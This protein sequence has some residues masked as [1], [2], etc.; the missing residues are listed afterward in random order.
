MRIASLFSSF[1]TWTCLCGVACTAA[2]A[3]PAAAQT[4]TLGR[5][6]PS[7]FEIIAVDPVSEPLWPF[8]N[9]DLA[10]DGQVTTTDTEASIDLRSVYADARSGRLWLRAYVAAKR[11]NAST[12]A[13]TG[14]FIDTDQNVATGGKAE[15]LADA[16]G[17]DASRGGYEV[18]LVVK[19][20][21]TLLG[22][23]TWNPTDRIWADR[24]RPEQVANVERGVARDPLRLLGDDRVYA[25]VSI[26]LAELKLDERCLANI[27][28]RTWNDQPNE[29]AYDDWVSS[30]AMAC[31]ARLNEFGDPEVLRSD[32]CDSDDSCPGNGV[33]RD[34][35][36]L[37]SYECNTQASCQADQRCTNNVCVHFRAD[38]CSSNAQCD[39]LVCDQTRCEVCSESGA[40]ACTGDGVCAPDGRCLSP[41]AA[42]S[43]EDPDSIALASGERVQGG[44][45]SCSL[46]H[47]AGGALTCLWLLLLPI[48]GRW[49]DRRRRRLRSKH[50]GAR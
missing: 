42:Y 13:F 44:A 18:A 26:E 11:P 49:T 17:K 35:I 3:Q 7:L 23:Y 4:W 33:C 12:T 21:G 40:R 24:L 41:S 37:F 28:V 1:W 48:A 30:F 25:Q 34:G 10:G 39:G 43:G 5:S 50:G 6:R 22:M 8:G 47:A 9:E 27:F 19:P 45:L 29:L 2:L 20:D 38:S 16:P 36:C 31:R 46:T 14:F 32:R 15:A